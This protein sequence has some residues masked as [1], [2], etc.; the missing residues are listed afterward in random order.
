MQMFQ[1]KILIG[2]LLILFSSCDY[3]NEQKNSRK[4]MKNQPV[5]RNEPKQIIY[6]VISIGKEDITYEEK[7]FQFPDSLSITQNQLRIWDNEGKVDVNLKKNGIN[8]TCGESFI[9]EFNPLVSWDFQKPDYKIPDL[10]SNN[11]SLI[12]GSKP[13]LYRGDRPKAWIIDEINKTKFNLDTRY[14]HDILSLI[15][16]NNDYL[17]VV[18]DASIKY[19]EEEYSFKFAIVKLGFSL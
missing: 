10:C 18:Y 1:S 8:L 13:R 7:F 11:K 12:L 6:D 15:R 3:S 17:L 2:L 16:V 19:N 4:F 5:T 14:F 9:Y